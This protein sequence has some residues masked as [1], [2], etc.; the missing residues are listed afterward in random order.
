M[1]QYN[2][3]PDPTNNYYHIGLIP[4]GGRRWAKRSGYSIEQSYRFSVE[5]LFKFIDLVVSKGIQEISIYGASSENFKRNP[6]NVN[7]FCQAFDYLFNTY[8]FNFCTR[9]KIFF[10][11]I[12]NHELFPDYLSKTISGFLSTPQNNS[13]VRINFLIGYDPISELINSFMLS[14]DYPDNFLNH[15]YIKNPVDLVIRT[16]G[17]NL[18]SNFLPLQCAYARIYFIPELFLDTSLEDIL[19][20][21]NSYKSLKRLY[22]E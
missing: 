11:V 8:L 15:L 4:D 16:G 3:L 13:D 5:Y 9:K 10:N 1:N 14:K 22:G 19:D 20:I 12:G 21:I 2:Y 7:A 18:L 6:D 17:A